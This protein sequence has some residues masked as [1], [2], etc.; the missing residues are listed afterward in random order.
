MEYIYAFAAVYFTLYLIKAPFV[1]AAA[2]RDTHYSFNKGY[3]KKTGWKFYFV[4]MTATSLFMAFFM[5]IPMLYM[6][7]WNFIKPYN[8]KD[9]ERAADKTAEKYTF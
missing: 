4:L 2:Y 8:R 3:I 7:R 6:E 9:I 5:L 1:I